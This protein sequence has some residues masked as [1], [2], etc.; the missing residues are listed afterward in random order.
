MPSWPTETKYISH[1]TTRI[2]G[3]AKVT[4]NARYSSDIQAEGWLYGMILR[5]N[6]RPRKSPA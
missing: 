3:A 2:D 6:G 1:P 5:S 4:G